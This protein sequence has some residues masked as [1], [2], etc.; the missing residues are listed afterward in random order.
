[1]KPR[2]FIV[3]DHEAVLRALECAL[4]ILMPCVIVGVAR[5]AADALREIPRLKPDVLWAD[6]CLPE[7]DGPNLLR[8]LK[9][10]DVHLGRV[11]CTGAASDAWIREAMLVEPEGFVS[12]YD[13]MGCWRKALESA[14]QGG[15]Y[16]SPRIAEAKKCAPD[17]ALAKLT[18]MERVMFSL[19]VQ[20][21]KKEDIAERLGISTH[22]A[23][24]HREH[25]MAKLGAHSGV[26]LCKIALRAGLME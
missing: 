20:N 1:M 9:V 25:L 16:C 11:L 22:T 6:V 26:D 7:I 5:N 4:P 14:S 23:R 3:D 12:K 8:L 19:A 24:H 2:V 21:K 13:E 15:S 18:D 10:R 17:K